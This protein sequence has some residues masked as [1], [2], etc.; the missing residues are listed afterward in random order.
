MPELATVAANDWDA[1]AGRSGPPHARLSACVGAVRA[2]GTLLS[3]R[4]G[5]RVRLGSGDRC[6]PG[7]LYDLDLPAV[8]SPRAGSSVEAIRRLWPQFLFART[9]EL[10][11]PTPLT[12]PFLVA[13]CDMRSAVVRAL[14]G[15]ALVEA[16]RCGAEFTLVQNFTSRETPRGEEL[17]RLGFAGVPIPATAV[18]DL[19]TRRSTST[20]RR[21][22][23]S[24][25]A[26]P[27]R[28]SAPGRTRGPPRV[29]R[30]AAERGRAG[31][32]ARANRLTAPPAGG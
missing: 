3:A 8:R 1:L 19:P 27:S 17:A 15:A 7:Y 4:D 13:D 2:E 23:L 16:Q 12:N 5:V 24:T 6:C 21:C 29:Q 25:A 20:C 32:T 30:A 18:L 9:Y 26:G 31:R 28:R 10:G 22:A 14:I 11:S